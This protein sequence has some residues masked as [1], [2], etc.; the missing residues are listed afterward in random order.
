M[1]KISLKN[2]SKVYKTSKP[3]CKFIGGLFGIEESKTAL[4]DI[5][6]DIYGGECVGIIGANGSGKST[7]LK[8]ISKITSATEGEVVTNGKISALL[9][10]GAGF[11]PEYTGISNIYL[12]G[13]LCGESRA[14]TKA[15]IPQIA[16]FADIGDYIKRPVKTYSDGMFL[17]LAFACAV[18]ENPDILVVDEALAVGDFAFR[19][20]CFA[21]IRELNAGGTTIIMVSHDIDTIRSF[22][23]RAIWLDSGRVRLD[24]DVMSVS[25]AYMESVTGCA[26]KPGLSKNADSFNCVN[27]FGSA[28]GSILSVSVPELLQT[29]EM[30]EILCRVEIPDG[31]DLNTLAFSVSIKNGLG[32]DITVISTADEGFLFDSY[33]EHMIKVTCP[34]YLSAGEYSICVSLEDRGSVPIKYYDYAE[35]AQRFRVVSKNEI[36]G[37]Y[38]APAEIEITKGGIEI[39]EKKR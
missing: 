3:R 5:N 22:C 27:R 4:K 9:E 17:R 18:S 20:K 8:L 35:G 29:G 13:M 23:K 30:A 15:K 7:L 6:I 26:G 24:G 21:K 1:M 37:I 25:A 14:Q 16:E 33:G 2:V 12:N 32:L 10:L 11:N 28:K 31:I 36:F 39:E 19:Q 38:R 34:C